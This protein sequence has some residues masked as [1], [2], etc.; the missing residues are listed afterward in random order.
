MT[1]KR[2]QINNVLFYGYFG[3]FLISNIFESFLSIY[4]SLSLEI[5]FIIIL[6]FA[7]NN[8]DLIM[9]NSKNVLLFL[10]IMFISIFS[11]LFAQGGF[12]SFFNLFNFICGILVFQCLEL[13]EKQY[14]FIKYFVL[15]LFLYNFYL[16]FSIWDNYVDG[17]N[18]FNPNSVGIFL[19]LCYVILTNFYKKKLVNIFL[20]IITIYAIYMTECR[21]A[22]LAVI[23]FFLLKNFPFI[24]RVIASK[25]SLILKCITVIGIIFPLIYVYLYQNNFNFTLPFTEKSLYTGR[26]YLWNIMLQALMTEPTGFILGLGT[27]HVTPAGVVIGNYHNW[28]FGTLYTFGIIIFVLYFYYLIYNIA[29]IKKPNIVFAFIALFII[30]FFETVGLWSTTQTYIYILLLIGNSNNI[31]LGGKN[32]CVCQK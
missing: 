10:F 9:R 1:I 31:H 25:S 2:D 4:T 27:N 22:L 19:F 26:E 11:L 30:G 6:I 5:N 15:I 20:F 21:S 14:R 32:E 7:L 23:A 28:Y 13:T 24:N 29:K 3:L 12:G 18:V 8:K 16:S 17:T